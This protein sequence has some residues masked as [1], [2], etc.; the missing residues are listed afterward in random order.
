MASK[1]EPLPAMINE[2]AMDYAEHQ[3]TYDGFVSLVKYGVL[4]LAILVV[5]LYFA[6]IGA[7]PVLGVVL[8]LAS[9][10]VPAVLAMLSRK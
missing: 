7:Q 1:H 2:S 4:S 10:V 8:I 9:V 5:G 6:I 3:R